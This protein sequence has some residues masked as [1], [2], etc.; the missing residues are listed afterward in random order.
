MLGAPSIRAQSTAP[1]SQTQ[2]PAFEVAS[3]KP[4]EPDARGRSIRPGPGGGVTI[5]NLTLK[6][7]IGLGWR[8]ESF[9]I[10]GGPAWLDSTRYNVIAKRE[11]KFQPAEQP[12]MIQSL[13]K[14]RFQLAIHRETRELRGLCP[15]AGKERRKTRPQTYRIEG[16]QLHA[17][18]SYQTSAR[19]PNPV[20]RLDNV[21]PRGANGREYPCIRSGSDAFA[22]FRANGGR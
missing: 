15:G 1:S 21:G 8:V 6:E 20:V 4:A 2:Q 11:G 12:L 18:R 19:T 3:I 5:S 17:T 10:S 7:M 9:Q 22:P 14:E 13:L 16:R